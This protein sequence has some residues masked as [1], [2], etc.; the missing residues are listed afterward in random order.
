MLLYNTLNCNFVPL[1]FTNLWFFL[2][3]FQNSIFGPLLSQTC[4][5]D[6]L[7]LAHFAKQWHP[8]ILTKST[9]MWQVTNMLRLYV[10]QRGL[11]LTCHVSMACHICLR[12]MWVIV[13][14]TRHADMTCVSHVTC[15]LNWSWGQNFKFVKIRGVKSV[16]LKVKGLKLQICKN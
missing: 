2:L 13:H 1:I 8:L 11:W 10:L 9:Y 4:D 7:N 5:F 6:S 3:N 12:G 16:I 15:A 14:A